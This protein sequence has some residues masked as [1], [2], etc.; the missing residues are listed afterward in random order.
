MTGDIP[1]AITRYLRASEDKDFETLAGCFTP[2]GAVLDEG[3]IYRGHDEIVGWRKATAAKWTFTTTVLAIECVSSEQY[4][5][6][7]H[8]QGDFPGGEADV[9]FTFDL[10]GDLISALRIEG[11]EQ[12]YRA[13]LR[14]RIT[15]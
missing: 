14:P 7:I 1:D 12:R 6:A 9:T 2:D 15:M 3:N 13:G 5:A 8:L 10:D 11:S 4:Q